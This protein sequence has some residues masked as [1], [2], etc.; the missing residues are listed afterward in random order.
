MFI[1]G[2]VYFS[3]TILIQYGFFIKSRPVKHEST[4]TG[5]IDDDVAEEKSRIE[6]EESESNDVLRVTNLTKIYRSVFRRKKLL[7]VDK[8]S[9]GLKS[10]ECFG[11]LGVN[12][13]G[14][15]T[16]FKMLT[17]DTNVTSGDAFIAKSS[18]LSDINDARQHMGYCPQFD[19]L[20][21]LLTAREMLSYYARIRGVRWKYVPQVA[22]WGIKTLDLILYADRICGD[23]S[24][25]NKRKLSTSI[26]FL[27]IPT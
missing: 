20:D 6:S 17:G 23:Y 5:K 2:I 8:L 14:K 9:F 1:G 10:G 4:S 18:I 22:E 27:P 26:A 7:A 19:A 25:G 21:E 16:T 3:I 24:G 15:T 12:G 11:L 13:A